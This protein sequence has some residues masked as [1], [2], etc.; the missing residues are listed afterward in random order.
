MKIAGLEKRTGKESGSP[1]QYFN[2][3]IGSTAWDCKRSLIQSI[4]LKKMVFS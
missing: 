4:S 2:Q 3:G 1:C